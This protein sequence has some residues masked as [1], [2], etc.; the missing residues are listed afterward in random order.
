M[1]PLRRASAS[2]FRLLLTY[3]MAKISESEFKL[4]DDIKRLPCES[5]KYMINGIA[6]CAKK[7]VGAG[8]YVGSGWHCSEANLEVAILGSSSS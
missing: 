3:T 5:T 2:I 1:F 6:V 4:I 7:G 8:E